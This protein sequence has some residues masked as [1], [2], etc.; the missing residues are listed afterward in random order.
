MKRQGIIIIANA[1]IWGLVMI[2]CSLAFKGTGAFSQIQHILGA[3]AAASLIINGMGA[4]PKK[5]NR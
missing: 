4:K 2:S 5:E 3:G 1:I